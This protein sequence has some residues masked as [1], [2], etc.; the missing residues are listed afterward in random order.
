[1]P[2]N[3]GWPAID[4]IEAAALLRAGEV[5][6]V[7]LV[8]VH[9]ERISLLDGELNACVTVT[10][11]DARRAATA[12]DEAR[13]AGEVSLL[14]GLPIAIKDNFET[15]GVLTT[16][17]SPS[18]AQHVPTRDAAVVQRLRAAGA[19]F[20]AKVNLDEFAFG[21]DSAN[22]VAGATRNPWDAISVPGGSSGGSGAAVAA[23]MCMGATASDTG[24]SIRN[25]SAWCGV[26]GFK[27]TFGAVSP[28]GII[29][30]AWS[31][32]TPGF[33]GRT[34]A[35]LALLFVET[36][37]AL[38]ADSATER[39]SALQAAGDVAGPPLRIG[40]VTS[41]LDDAEKAA[42]PPLRAAV[43]RL[44]DIADIVDVALPRQDDALAAFLTI[45]MAE[46]S[47]A[48]EAGLRSEWDRFGPPVRALL[49]AGRLIRATEYLHAQR[50]REAVRREIDRLFNEVDA[51]VMPCMGIAPRPHPF[52]AGLSGPDSPIWRLAVRFTSMWNLT[53]APVVSLPCG[54]TDDDRP[55]AMQLVTR[56]GSDLRCLQV[57]TRA[58][59][60]W[61]IP[62]ESL[63]P[64]WVRH[65]LA[66]RAPVATPASGAQ[67]A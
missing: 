67:P 55:V 2:G 42:Q 34:C 17:G 22:P 3:L 37:D 11:E 33:L 10:A 26:S 4:M 27:P 38:V 16:C 48:W 61:A 41:S 19:A 6:A 56:P 66:Q 14:L 12:A 32:D 59:A 53:G 24:G 5:S 49:D 65:Q 25:P 62:R 8:D 21:G 28:A 1:M 7:E 39:R 18:L 46:G 47:A 30:L 58:E 23:G 35:D 52:E 13:K 60:A 63:V 36:A 31:L 15:A 43:D 64:T 51:I 9:I 50:V 57:G 29:P 20:V 40:V 44:G 45:I 54:F